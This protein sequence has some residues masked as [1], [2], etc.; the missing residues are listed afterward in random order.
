[1]LAVGNI[2]TNPDVTC[3]RAILIKSWYADVKNPAILSVVM[4]QP[5]LHF[6]LLSAIKRLR[7]DVETS[8]QIIWVDTF[9]PAV[10]KLLLHRSS[11]E[12]QPTPVEVGTK[13][14]RTRH[15]HKHGRSI[16]DQPETLFALPYCFFS[17]VTFGDVPNHGGEELLTARFNLGDGSFDRKFFTSCSQAP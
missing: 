12:I 9:R 2:N 10:S 7:I 6:E 4:T 17:A 13:F 11:G 5:I 15:P 16:R 14:V 8:L 1:M 3:K